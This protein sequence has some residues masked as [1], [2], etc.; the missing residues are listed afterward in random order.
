[1]GQAGNQSVPSFSATAQ[2]P[3]LFLL[4]CGR[5][6]GSLHLGGVDS[7][8]CVGEGE[9]DVVDPLIQLQYCERRQ[10]RAG[11]QCA[12]SPS[13][14][15]WC[16]RRI[17]K[18]SSRFL[19]GIL[20]FDN[21]MKK[22]KQR[23]LK[24]WQLQQ[25]ANNRTMSS[26][27]LSRTSSKGAVKREP[28]EEDYQAN[29]DDYDHNNEERDRER[30]QEEF[31]ITEGLADAYDKHFR[32]PMTK[33]EQE[34]AVVAIAT[35]AVEELEEEFKRTY[36]SLK[37]P[38]ELERTESRDS[39]GIPLPPQEKPVTKSGEIDKR[40][41]KAYDQKHSGYRFLREKHEQGCAF[42]EDD[43][44]QHLRNEGMV[45]G[46]AKKNLLEKMTSSRNSKKTANPRMWHSPRAEYTHIDDNSAMLSVT[47]LQKQVEEYQARL[48][49]E[50]ERHV[51][52]I[53]SLEQDIRKAFT[54]TLTLT[55]TLNVGTRAARAAG[56]ALP[57]RVA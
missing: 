9:V 35:A 54:L 24:Q 43:L 29:I 10:V 15:H 52:R 32:P 49:K 20:V 53:T 30:I 45:T 11:E 42:T 47:S 23:G 2:L 1:M 48:D 38:G 27:P 44:A 17:D 41:I 6:T 39:F 46:T 50:N 25:F 31:G 37:F 55:L 40:S 56:S 19:I 5:R 18:T 26:P 51:K 14:M 8:S 36:R 12:M 3:Q 57:K 4:L 34:Q 16:F 22:E 33:Q 21:R 28:W 7:G 13:M